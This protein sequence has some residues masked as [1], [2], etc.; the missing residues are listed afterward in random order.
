MAETIAWRA[1]EH[2]H[3]PKEGDWFWVLGI[4]AVSSAL[5][6]ILLSDILFAILILDAAGTLTIMSMR[7]ARE[8]SF[9]ISNRGIK[10]DDMFF[11]YDIID[12][13]WINDEEHLLLINTHRPMH[14]HLVLPL[15]DEDADRVRTFLSDHVPE[16][17]IVEPLSHKI[18]EFFGF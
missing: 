5:T 3:E 13:F 1:L 14:A 4:V 2:K 11:S 6:A 7:P 16:N 17:L 10:A 15:A 8:V 18:M 12:A 9:E